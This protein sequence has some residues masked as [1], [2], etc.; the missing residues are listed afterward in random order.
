MV[1]KK[2]YV[3][4]VKVDIGKKKKE[5]DKYM[6]LRNQKKVRYKQFPVSRRKITSSKMAPTTPATTTIINAKSGVTPFFGRE[7]GELKQSVENFISSI[8][9]LIV[10]KNLTE[11]T[12][13][14]NEAKSYLD[15][16]KGDLAYWSRTIGFRNCKNWESLKSFLR[17]VYGGYSDIGLVRD[18]G[19][20]LRH[21]DRKGYSM[22]ANG[23]KVNDRMLEFVAKLE[24]T[25]WVE[26]GA[27]KLDNFAILIQLGIMI[28]SLPEPLVNTFD[29]P[30][31]KQSSETDI[32]DQVIK[33]KGKLSDFDITI[34]E[35]KETMNKTKKKEN[36]QEIGVVN[37]T[38]SRTHPT[39][40][41]GGG[42][43]CHNC[44]R[45]GH[46]I[47]NCYAHYCSFHNTTGHSYSQCFGRN[48]KYHN[49]FE[50]NR[51]PSM[52]RGWH[53]NPHRG[54]RSPS[55]NRGWHNNS[56][57]GSNSYSRNINYNANGKNVN[58]G[59]SQ[60]HNNSNIKGE[61]QVR[62]RNQTPSPSHRNPNF[63]N[64]KKETKNT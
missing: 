59:R 6:I 54:N 47:R 46:V 58:N 55:V 29:K 3:T 19:S 26:N 27:I 5:D 28:A 9:S 16:S 36:T 22:V 10:T 40:N 52:N 24:P 57:G 50:G 30:L 41:M 34:L 12:L 60:Y 42:V 37:T 38:D 14:L 61:G 32:M 1:V 63:W 4:E 21:V 53:N 48:N 49:Q 7:A 44:N 64:A 17:K 45:K 20:V 39:V 56:Q 11:E 8:E 23:A 25:D 13:I 2:K 33:H 51:S 15:F 62:G 43:T 31:T 18:L 35:G